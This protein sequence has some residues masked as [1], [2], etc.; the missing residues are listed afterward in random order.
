MSAE[1]DLVWSLVSFYKS[2]V[3]SSGPI[4]D[5]YDFMT[6]EEYRNTL[7][8]KE[9]MSLST[10]AERERLSVSQSNPSPCPFILFKLMRLQFRFAHTCLPAIVALLPR[11]RT[12]VRELLSE[13]TA[14]YPAVELFRDY[15]VH[16]PITA[17]FI[18]NNVDEGYAALDFCLRL[19]ILM[20]GKSRI[21]RAFD[22]GLHGE[23]G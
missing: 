1:D 15:L 17:R 7:D 12:E 9:L 11:S 8:W 14:L 4:L 19:T 23:E 2:R 18:R 13:N 20:G 3:P 6:D 10:D 16:L 22:W 21:V 5:R